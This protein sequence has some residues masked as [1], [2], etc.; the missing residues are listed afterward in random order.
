MSGSFRQTLHGVDKGPACGTES[1]IHF[2]Q[3]LCIG[4]LTNPYVSAIQIWIDMIVGGTGSVDITA[5][6]QL[7]MAI[8]QFF[9]VL[10]HKGL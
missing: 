3:R 5:G 1:Q 10:S 6:K 4:F 9:F 2:V 7:I 8:Q